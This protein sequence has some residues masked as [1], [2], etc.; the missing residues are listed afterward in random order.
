MTRPKIFSFFNKKLISFVY[1][2]IAY[3]LGIFTFKLLNFGNQIQLHLLNLPTKITILGPIL[4][5]KN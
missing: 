4:I 3:I 1:N 5:P 2:E